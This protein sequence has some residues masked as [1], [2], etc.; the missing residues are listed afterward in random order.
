MQK[1]TPYKVSQTFQ[2]RPSPFIPFSHC[3]IT[4][5]VPI[6]GFSGQTSK[7]LFPGCGSFGAEMEICALSPEH[8]SY[9]ECLFHR[10][11]T[12]GIRRGDIF[13]NSGNAWII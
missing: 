6:Y 4:S 1:T 10:E 7:H 11:R 3:F 13:D 2:E 8:R 9:R 12:P 5:S